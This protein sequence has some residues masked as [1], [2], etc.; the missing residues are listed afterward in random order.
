MN[1][2]AKQRNKQRAAL[3]VKAIEATQEQSASG[4]IYREDATDTFANV[5]HYCEQRGWDVETLMR[6]GREHAS[7]ELDEATSDD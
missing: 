1:N 5:A 3:G 6:L 2:G 7:Y 4:T